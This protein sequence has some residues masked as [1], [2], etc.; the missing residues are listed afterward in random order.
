MPGYKNMSRLAR[1][2]ANLG[3]VV[4]ITLISEDE[5]LAATTE[6][7]TEALFATGEITTAIPFIAL[8]VGACLLRFD[9]SQCKVDSEPVNKL[10]YQGFKHKFSGKIAGND[11]AQVL[12][13][14]SFRN[15]PAVAVATMPDGTRQVLGTLINPLTIKGGWTTGDANGEKQYEVSGEMETPCAFTPPVLAAGVAAIL[16]AP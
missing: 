16:I 2:T 5:F 4:T 3:G 11:K 7:P 6:W 1:G 14:N 15:R 8:Y 12:A 13:V 10:G 9:S